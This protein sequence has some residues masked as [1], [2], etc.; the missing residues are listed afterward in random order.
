MQ[1]EIKK[2]VL[3][4]LIQEMD[5][6]ILG[7]IKAKRSPQEMIMEETEVSP[8]KSCEVEMD[9]PVEEISEQPMDKLGMQMIKKAMGKRT[10]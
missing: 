1:D 3:Q 6:G 8:M 9:E 10:M 2:L 4:Q 7:D 5:D